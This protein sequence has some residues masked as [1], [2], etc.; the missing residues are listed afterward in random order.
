[1]TNSLE[2][3]DAL[4]KIIELLSPFA[5]NDRERI[6]RWACEKLDVNVT[7]SG[8]TA[9]TDEDD[10]S[11]AL[12]DLLRN[13]AAREGP[14]LLN[15]QQAFRE[16]VSTGNL[17]DL[18]QV[19]NRFVELDA[20][21]NVVMAAGVLASSGDTDAKDILLDLIRSQKVDGDALK[22]CVSTL[23][24]YYSVRD[25]EQ[26]GVEELGPLIESLVQS[27][28]DE[29]TRAFF[30]NQ[31]ARLVYGSGDIDRALAI[32]TKVYETSPT[33]S[34]YVYNLSVIYERMGELKKSAALAKEFIEMGDVDDVDHITHAIQVLSKAGDVRY[35]ARL[36]QKLRE[37]FPARA[38]HLMQADENVRELA[39]ELRG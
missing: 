28:P 36:L 13:M 22:S 7:S 17:D 19:M 9:S 31:L 18:K 24:Q 33:D 37:R 12:L 1:M 6:L 3:L 2:D 15:P 34:A 27:S 5:P 35:A 38:R 4:R 21:E 14:N 26:E 39:H 10:N 23:V 8:A 25:L 11:E 29:T 20:S 16:A 32:Q 30:L